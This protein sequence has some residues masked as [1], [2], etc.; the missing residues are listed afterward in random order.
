MTCK[1]R[2]P[3][4]GKGF[5][6]SRLHLCWPRPIHSV[7]LSAALHSK[8]SSYLMEGSTK[9]LGIKSQSGCISL[10]YLK[11]ASPL[12]VRL[13]THTQCCRGK[14]AF[15][16]VTDTYFCIRNTHEWGSTITQAVVTDTDWHNGA[17]W[18]QVTE[19]NISRCSGETTTLPLFMQRM[20][21]TFVC[22]TKPHKCYGNFTLFNFLK[23]KGRNRTAAAF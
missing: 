22:V 6:M 4:N 11:G 1:L 18:K 17:H 3:V 14:S 5:Y 16:A 23:K 2:Y 7:A 21:Q 12:L 9:Q 20:N 15:I 10:C 13:Q 8:H 19:Q